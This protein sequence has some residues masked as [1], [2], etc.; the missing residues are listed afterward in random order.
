MFLDFKIPNGKR[1]IVLLKVLFPVRSFGIVF[2][3]GMLRTVCWFLNPYP[4]P[5]I[6]ALTVLGFD[7]VA[8]GPRK[9]LQSMD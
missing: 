7:A 5:A 8:L 3:G 4:P 2:L 6:G 1:E 9:A